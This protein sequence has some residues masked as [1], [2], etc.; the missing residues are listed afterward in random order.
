MGGTNSLID[1][2][3]F[4]LFVR[5]LPPTSAAVASSTICMVISLIVNGRFTFG[6]GGPTLRQAVRFFLITASVLW[7][8]QPL[9]I[10]LILLPAPADPTWQ[11]LAFAKMA[12][13]GVCFLANFFLYRRFVWPAP[14]RSEVDSSAPVV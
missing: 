12:A 5:G 1:L 6:Q 4:L 8:L 14:Q 11:L 3:L 9:L 10:K 2:G 7:V 13:I